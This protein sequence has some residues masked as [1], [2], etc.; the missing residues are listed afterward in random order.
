MFDTA[1]QMNPLITL[2]PD[3][4]DPAV[5]IVSYDRVRIGTVRERFTPEQTF[6]AWR[7]GVLIY[8]PADSLE[9]AAQALAD[10][11]TLGERTR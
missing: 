5:T 6:D 9:R 2:T 7:G 1:F 8:S 4:K 10:Y 11:S 3:R